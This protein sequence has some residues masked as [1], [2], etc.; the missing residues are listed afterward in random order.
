MPTR[1]VTKDVANVVEFYRLVGAA[2]AADDVDDPALAAPFT[3]LGN[4]DGMGLSMLLRGLT[5]VTATSLTMD[6]QITPPDS[7]DP[8]DRFA[9]ELVRLE[10]LGDQAAGRLLTL[11]VITEDGPLAAMVAIALALPIAI[12]VQSGQ[13]SLPD[14]TGKGERN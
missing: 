8:E 7:T 12:L 11:M 1:D 10:R 2:I 9:E 14:L 6:S 5:H 13:M 4:L 3:F